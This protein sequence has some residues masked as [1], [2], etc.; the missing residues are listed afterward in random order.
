MNSSPTQQPVL[1]IAAF[2]YEPGD[3]VEALMAQAA[4]ALREVGVRIGG[5]VQHSVR[6]NEEARCRINLENIGTGAVYPMSQNL[7]AASQSCA[8]D[9]NALADASW[10]L[11]QAVTDEAQLV[12]INKFGA[13]EAG[14]SGLRDEMMQ[15]AMA[16]I[17]LLTSVG[18]R[19]LPQWHEFMGDGAI[20]LPLSLDAAIGWWQRLQPPRESVAGLEA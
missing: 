1:P 8:L 10:V 11:R 19:F 2:L 14:G 9:V 13:Q 12:I 17:P 4:Q 18:R 15:V 20:L 3:P 6:D 7:G 16:G 5:L